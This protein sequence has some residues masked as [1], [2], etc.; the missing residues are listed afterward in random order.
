[1]QT[2]RVLLAKP[3]AGTPRVEDFRVESAALG[4]PGD[5]EMLCRTHY[6][7]LDPYI[8]SV[9]G[10]R[11][12]SGSAQIGEI[13]PGE[14]ISEVLESRHPGFQAGQLIAMHSGWQSHF[15]SNG[16]TTRGNARL[17]EAGQLPAS[18][19]LGVLGMPGL[20]AYSGMTR[21]AEP[22]S[23]DTLVVSAAAGPVG[24]TVGQIGRLRGCRVVGIAGSKEKCAWVTKEAGFDACIDYRQEN[25]RE[26]LTKHCPKGVDIYFDN[27]G[28][29]T[30]QAV[31]EQL[32][33]GARVV[34]CGLISQYNSDTPPVGP[35][36]GLI[37]RARATVRGLVVYDHEDLREQMV[38]QH[39]TWISA[40]EMRYREDIAT[41]LEQTP[42]AF[43][44]LMEGKNF[45]KSIV[46][47]P[48]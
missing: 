28:G 1:M 3:P 45:G 19:F 37:I 24:A 25:L 10:G 21:L 23:G 47:L 35:N 22:R 16:V 5:G 30:L 27:V 32:S 42:A 7:S 15:I 29:D 6:L 40:G 14:A 43:V 9:L 2:T 18:L 36:P 41:G 13:I 26:A 46:H 8:R 44:R 31:M 48:T 34:L 38:R 20:T 39:S 17:I 12:I 4:A 11:H 33:Q